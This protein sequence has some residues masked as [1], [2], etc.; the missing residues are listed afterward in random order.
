[1]VIWYILWSVGIFFPVLVCCTKKILANQ[2]RAASV[3]LRSVEMKQTSSG[4]EI[5]SEDG[6]GA[7]LPRMHKSPLSN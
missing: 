4:K 3:R 6:F 7:I 2:I 1:M 5:L